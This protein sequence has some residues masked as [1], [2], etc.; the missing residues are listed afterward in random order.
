[1]EWTKQTAGT[2]T[3]CKSLGVKA[4]PKSIPRAQTASPSWGGEKN[5]MIDHI[6][7]ADRKV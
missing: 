3:G 7:F 6:T 1:M 5:E 4:A 2:S